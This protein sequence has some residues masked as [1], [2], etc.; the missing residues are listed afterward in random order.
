V[1]RPS[2]AFALGLAAGALVFGWLTVTEAIP[3][4]LAALGAQ[5]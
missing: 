2:P 5:P 1:L 4:F 3:Q